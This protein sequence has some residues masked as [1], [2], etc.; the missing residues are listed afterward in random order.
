MLF[1]I[2]WLIVLFL[3]GIIIKE[4]FTE[5]DWRKQIALVMVLIVFVLRILLIK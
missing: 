1:W 3:S 5:K 4:L 2:Y